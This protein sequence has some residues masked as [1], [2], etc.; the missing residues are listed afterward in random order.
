MLSIVMLNVVMLSVVVLSVIAPFLDRV[1]QIRVG[2]YVK[3]YFFNFTNSSFRQTASRQFF[4]HQKAK[5]KLFLTK[6][7]FLAWN[8]KNCIS[9]ENCSRW[10]L[11]LQV[12]HL[13]I[14]HL[15]KCKVSPKK[16]SQQ[17][18][19]HGSGFTSAMTFSFATSSIMT[20][21]LT[22]IKCD[23]HHNYT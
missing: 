20:F 14:T 12:G 3:D 19:R 21:S 10:Y 22:M 11:L 13:N 8:S 1:I 6:K 7:L 17:R 18:Q 16:C 23:T 2:F 9:I 5:M 4:F 15:Y